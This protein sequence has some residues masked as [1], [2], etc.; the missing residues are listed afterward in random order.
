MTDREIKVSI[1]AG[2][3]KFRGTIPAL[4]SKEERKAKVSVP[5]MTKLW[6]NAAVA[7]LALTLM[8]VLLPVHVI[9]RLI[10]YQSVNSFMIWCCTRQLE[11]ETVLKVRLDVLLTS[12]STGS[13]EP[14]DKWS[15]WYPSFSHGCAVMPLLK[16]GFVFPLSH[17]VISDGVLYLLPST[18][19]ATVRRTFNWRWETPIKITTTSPLKPWR[20][21]TDPAST[22]TKRNLH[23]CGGFGS[24]QPLISTPNQN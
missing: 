5:A 4:E 18:V 8:C 7:I 12:F 23:P 14:R 20:F 21:Q 1:A 17:S 19:T 6:S 3:I 22:A 10:C 15:I 16:A 11:L 24:S 2:C 9:H 13:I